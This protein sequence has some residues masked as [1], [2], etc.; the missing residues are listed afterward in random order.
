[1]CIRKR[2]QANCQIFYSQVSFKM[3]V[4][5]PLDTGNHL[6]SQGLH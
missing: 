2:I 5:Q 1:M 4:Y 6:G 3:I